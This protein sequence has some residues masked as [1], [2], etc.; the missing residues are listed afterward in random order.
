MKVPLQDIARFIKDDL[1]KQVVQL[2][3]K[4]IN[5]RISV[6]FVGDSES[7]LAHVKAQQKVARELGIEFD[8][9]HLTVAPPFLQFANRLKALSQ[10]PAVHGII[11]A[12]PLPVALQSDTIYNFIP[13]VKEI[14][15]H[16]KKTTYL[17]PIGL[18]VITVLK[19][20]FQSTTINAKLYPD[21]QKDPPFF[22]QALKQKKVVLIGRGQSAGQPI[23]Q[24]MAQ[25]RINFINVNAQTFEP[26]QYYQDADVIVTS[27]GKK[28]LKG[29]DIK[30]GAAL[31]NVSAH[32]EGGEATG[33]YEESD[34]KTIARFYTPTAKGTGAIDT[35][36]LFKNLIQAATPT[37]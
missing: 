21:L 2:K 30:Q 14:S 31:I 11:I 17:P 18:T 5:P 19:Y 32:D 28:V 13:L 16:R 20:M 25:F 7:R 9:I 3:K 8:L 36:F 15:G 1:A 35:L 27:V 12:E 10:D 24:T 29:S 26:E 6:F 22:K 37:E 4:K 33:D 34:V 23:A